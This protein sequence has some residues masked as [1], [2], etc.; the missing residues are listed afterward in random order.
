MTKKKAFNL[1]IAT[2]GLGRVFPL[3]SFLYLEMKNS[4]RMTQNIEKIK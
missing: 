4:G 1:H 3:S 2:I